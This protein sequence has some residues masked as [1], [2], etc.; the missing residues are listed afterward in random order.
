MCICSS[1]PLVAAC[2]FVFLFPSFSLTY[3][4]QHTH[5]HLSE[6]IFWHW[7]IARH[8]FH[9][10]NKLHMKASRGM[11]AY[12]AA[13]AQTH[14]CM[15]SHFGCINLN[16]YCAPPRLSLY[17]HQFVFHYWH[18]QCVYVPPGYCLY[19][20]PEPLVC[21]SLCLLHMNK[22]CKKPMTAHTHTHR[23]RK[24]ATPASHIT[25]VAAVCK[26]SI[27]GMHV[28][29]CACLVFKRVA[30]ACVFIWIKPSVCLWTSL[31]MQHLHTLTVSSLILM[32]QIFI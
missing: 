26:L 32:N 16:P 15:S 24:N 12:S 23:H 8:L 31:L 11:F 5:T 22:T 10:C 25:S 3:I 29:V 14:M 13:G 4:Q 18:L 28:H 2:L 17:K 1:R 19:M 30:P 27:M 9:V 7:S 21:E 20:W 6:E